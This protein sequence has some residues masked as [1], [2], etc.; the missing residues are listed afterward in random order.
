MDGAPKRPLIVDLN[1]V[2][3]VPCPCG[4]SRRGLMAPDNGLCSLHRVSISANARPHRHQRM[5]EVYYF[6]EGTGEIELDGQRTPVRP[7]MAVMIPPGVVHRAVVAPGQEMTI[8][9]FVLP[10]FDPED[11]IVEDYRP[12]RPEQ[13]A[14]PMT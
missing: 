2:Q 3:P 5:T 6:L 13:A 4:Q 12:W 7:G 10:P 8:L 11:E 9:N 1:A 14:D